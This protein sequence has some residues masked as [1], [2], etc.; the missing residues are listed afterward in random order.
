MLEH[1]FILY[2]QISTDIRNLKD[3]VTDNDYVNKPDEY[4]KS[5]T[6][7]C[8]KKFGETDRKSDHT[9]L[10]HK[11]QNVEFTVLDSQEQFILGKVTTLK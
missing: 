9:R 3:N 2:E 5:K 7:I 8:F 10:C 11:L 6:N 1:Y 4:F